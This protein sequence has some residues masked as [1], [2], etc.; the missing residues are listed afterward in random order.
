MDFKLSLLKIIKQYSV[1]SIS[2]FLKN[3]AN[4]LFKQAHLKSEP[5]EINN[6]DNKKYEMNNIINIKATKK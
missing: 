2:L 4:L 5:V 3:P 6:N 1:F